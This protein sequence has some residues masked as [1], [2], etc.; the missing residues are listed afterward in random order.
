MKYL[1][2]LLFV[3][4]SAASAQSVNL[5]DLQQPPGGPV[6]PG[7]ATL[8]VLQFRIYKDVGSAASTITQ[9]K[10]S[11]NTTSSDWDTIYLYWDVDASRTY[12]TG[13]QMLG[14][15]TISSGGKVTFPGLSQPI[16]DGF[17]GGRDYLGVVDIAGGATPGN[18]FSMDIDAPD[19]SVSAGS[20]SAPLGAVNSNLH[21]IRVDPGCEIDVQRA[22]TSIPSSTYQNH[23][24]GYIPTTSGT[25]TFNVLNSGTATLQLNGSTTIEFLSPSNCTAALTGTPPSTSIASM[26]S[27]SF[28]V[29]VD[30]NL[31]SA[32]SFVIRIRSDDFDEDPYIIQCIGSAIP[33]P[34]IS[35]EYSSAEVP[36]GDLITLG[37]Y[38][39]GIASTLNFTIKNTGAADLTLGGTPIVDFPTQQNVNCT[40]QTP[41]STPVSAGSG[42]TTFVVSFTP[43]GSGNWVFT[44]WI[45]SN[46]QNEN[47]YNLTVEGSSPPVTP[48]KL[49][50]FRNPANA[51][52]TLSFGTQPVVSVQ[53]GNGAVDTSNNST[54]V[55]ASITTGTGA[56]GA[57][58]VGTVT[59]T[60]VNGYATFSNLGINTEATGYTLTYTDQAA[61]LTPTVSGSF[62]VGPAPPAPPSDS[63]GDGGGCSSG[64][65]G[66]PWML[67]CAALAA[68][69]VAF[70]AL[71]GTSKVS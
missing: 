34:E 5:V 21:T 55:V 45:E 56:S 2:L 39:A 62:D 40:L 64:V 54:V 25:V 66:A 9:I 69:C 41:P 6:Q 30:P 58:L 18:T 36:D 53:D 57:A 27:T 3:L 14:S 37:S 4:G 28:T 1:A 13:D 29:D 59:A 48:I 15:T 7:T 60:C 23:D 31:T 65:P 71:A 68:L 50:V 61:T 63:G 52:A 38:T 16:Q 32:F 12:T 47:P 46:D 70:R 67:I 26:G 33:Y 17:Y 8:N 44:I 42:S 51:S 35:V 19:V 22:S 24:I 10:F 49:G 11:I 20:V 43:A